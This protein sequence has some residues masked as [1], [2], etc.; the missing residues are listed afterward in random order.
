MISSMP[1]SDTEIF[2]IIRLNLPQS[3][4]NFYCNLARLDTVVNLIRK[5]SDQ[6]AGVLDLGCGSFVLDYLLENKGYRQIVAVDREQAFQDLYFRLRRKKVLNYT[7]FYRSHVTR[8]IQSARDRADLVLLN[9]ASFFS[10]LTLTAIIP[11]VSRIL[12]DGGYFIFDIWS[13]EFYTRFQSVYHFLFPRYI[14]YRRYGIEEIKQLLDRERFI[15]EET[16]PHFSY[17]PLLEEAQKLIWSLFHESNTLYFVA[18][19]A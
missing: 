19:K 18:R 3:E 10:G 6:H 1:V 8:Y 14:Q 11:K 2:N 9:D 12:R 17:K 4:S 13:R 7:R 5:Y 15:I 16:T